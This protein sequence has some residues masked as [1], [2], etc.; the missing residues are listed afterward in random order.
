[1]VAK[2]AD[3]YSLDE[4]RAT[5]LAKLIRDDDEGV[6]KAGCAGATFGTNLNGL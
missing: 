2:D 6:H 3:V 4:L 5:R 1:M